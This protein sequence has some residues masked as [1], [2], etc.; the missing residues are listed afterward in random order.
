MKM[1][2]KIFL[3]IALLSLVLSA[4]GKN[5]KEDCLTMQDQEKRNE[6]IDRMHE[7]GEVLVPTK[8]PK[9]W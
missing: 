3:C 4:C 6:C 2:T 8:D 7:R 1:K 5:K 9:K